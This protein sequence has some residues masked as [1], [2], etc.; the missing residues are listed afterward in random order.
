MEKDLPDIFELYL[1]KENIENVFAKKLNSEIVT[2][3]WLDN[4]LMFLGKKFVYDEEHLFETHATDIKICNK[5]RKFKNSKSSFYINNE[6]LGIITG[7]VEQTSIKFYSESNL[8]FEFIPQNDANDDI[9]ETRTFSFWN[10]ETFMAEKQKIFINFMNKIEIIDFE[11]SFYSK[12]VHNGGGYTF[13]CYQENKIFVENE[14]SVQS[15]NLN[16]KKV[17]TLIK[18]KNQ[19]KGNIKCGFVFKNFLF[20]GTSKNYLYV[21][22]K[23]NIILKYKFKN[24]IKNICKVEDKI[25]I[26][27]IKKK[28]KI[29][30]NGQ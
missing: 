19:L 25:I 9:F 15:I 12:K 14:N 13:L 24:L 11:K 3:G 7:V 28:K 27:T 4:G 8:L 20:L 17:L 30:N 16:T 10:I 6:K 22:S 1:D 21:Y 2:Y 5:T 26:L 18:K 29:H 23:K